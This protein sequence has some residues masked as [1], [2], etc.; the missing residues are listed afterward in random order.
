MSNHLLEKCAVPNKNDKNDVIY[1]TAT[2]TSA[3]ITV[4]QQR[5]QYPDNS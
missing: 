1:V 2:N 3:Y 5:S 4:T